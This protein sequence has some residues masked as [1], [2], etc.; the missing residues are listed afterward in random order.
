[1]NRLRHIYEAHLAN[2]WVSVAKDYGQNVSAA[3]LEMKWRQAHGI[4]SPLTPRGSCSP[5]PGYQNCQ[6]GV[7]NARAERERCEIGRLLGID[8]SPRSGE[9]RERVRRR[10]QGSS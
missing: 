8:A 4:A 5:G 9:E 3:L 7:D 10:E 1:M 2:F 6:S